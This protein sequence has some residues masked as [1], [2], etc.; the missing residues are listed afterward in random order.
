MIMI[1]NVVF[2]KFM[3]IFLIKC[4]IIFFNKKFSNHKMLNKV[5]QNSYLVVIN[6]CRI[7]LHYL[8]I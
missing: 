5:L 7:C 6:F 3:I 2:I 8:H 4:K 1:E